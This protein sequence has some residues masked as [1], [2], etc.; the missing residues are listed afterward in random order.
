ML[1]KTISP[2]SREILYSILIKVEPKKFAEYCKH[3]LETVLPSQECEVRTQ[4]LGL[5]NMGATCYMNS[6]LQQFFMV[7]KFRWLILGREVK[8]ALKKAEVGGN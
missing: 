5:K 2:K 6:I 7:E 3:M 8:G 4:Y 1:E